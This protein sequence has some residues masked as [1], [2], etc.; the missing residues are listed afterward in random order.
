MACGDRLAVEHRVAGSTVTYMHHG[1]DVGDGTVVH[2]RPDDFR[3]PFA[4]GRVV[5]TP[6]EEFAAGRPVRTVIDPPA[7]FAA[8]AIVDRALAA[9]GRRLAEPAW[10]ML[11]L[12]E[13]R[14]D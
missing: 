9:V 13:G 11:D 14:E 5:R 7:R 12:I 10:D 2:A 6:L 4:G 8:D 3:N 1:I